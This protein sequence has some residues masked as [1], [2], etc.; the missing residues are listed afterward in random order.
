[1]LNSTAGLLNDAIPVPASDE[2]SKTQHHHK[3]PWRVSLGVVQVQVLKSTLSL[4]LA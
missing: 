2:I 1:M 3:T 4:V